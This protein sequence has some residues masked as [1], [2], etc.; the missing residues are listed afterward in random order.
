MLDHD[1]DGVALSR[2]EL[3]RLIRTAAPGLADVAMLPRLQHRGASHAEVVGSVDDDR[4]C[5]GALDPPASLS[6]TEHPIRS[7]ASPMRP[8]QPGP[9]RERL[10][11]SSIPRTALLI[12][13]NEKIKR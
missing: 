4:H 9:R 1:S 2:E 6:R 10:V 12:D 7:H 8:S 3:V 13:P 11:R 5:F